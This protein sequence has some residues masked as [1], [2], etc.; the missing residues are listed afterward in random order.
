MTILILS[1]DV[2]T[3]KP[4]PPRPALCAELGA[5]GFRTTD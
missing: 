2:V 5:E 3:E 4:G 1:H